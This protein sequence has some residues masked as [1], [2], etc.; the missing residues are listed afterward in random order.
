MVTLDTCFDDLRFGICHSESL[1][2]SNTDVAMVPQRRIDLKKYVTW[3]AV[4]YAVTR[5]VE[6]YKER[7]LECTHI[8]GLH[9]GG[10]IPAVMLSHRLGLP[11]LK[12]LSPSNQD[13]V[14][15]VDDIADTGETLENTCVELL[16]EVIFTLH[17]HERSS[18]EPDFYVFEKGDD[19]IVY[20]WEDGEKD[21]IQ[22]YKKGTGI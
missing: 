17:K 9:R 7:G 16:N 11:L 21:E 3:D 19:W 1:D 22:D 14:L 4:D 5:M 15:V 2:S 18:I 13:K 6:V 12:E 8:Y 20:P 10:Y